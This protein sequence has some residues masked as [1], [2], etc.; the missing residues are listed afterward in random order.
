[1][2]IIADDQI[3][4]VEAFFGPH[5]DL[6]Q[7][8]AEAI[9]AHDVKEADLLLIRTVHKMH[10]EWLDNSRVK[11]VASAT[12]GVD[13]VE[14]LQER[15]IHFAHAPGCN[16]NAVA[17]YVVCCVAELLQSGRLTENALAG[18]IGVG[19]VGSRVLE[20]LSI[21]HF[22]TLANDPPRSIREPNFHSDSLLE[23]KKADLICV[24]TP[25][26]TQGDFPSFQL[27][28]AGFLDSLKKNSIVLNAGRGEVVDEL[29]FLQ[30]KNVL[31]CADVW[32]NEPNINSDFLGRS[33]I[34]TPHIAGYSIQA[35]YRAT[36]QIYEAACEFFGWTR[37]SVGVNFDILTIPECSSWRD[38]VLH[39]LNPASL[40]IQKGRFSENRRNY[41]FRNEFAYCEVDGSKIPEKDIAILR[42][43]G[44]LFRC[45]SLLPT[46][47]FE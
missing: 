28:N 22:T 9:N 19:H 20:K 44:F 41:V 26:T 5:G 37:K 36:E 2:K 23:F 24:H 29:A 21:L 15:G 6:I 3:P 17:E 11:M 4:L 27:I 8:P 42:H 13:H 46:I 16:A 12:A 43:L 34:A 33:L 47:C 30:R 7:K 40:R 14:G 45:R 1:M 32:V 35:K 39:V 18:V 25:L 10:P 31:S 38:V